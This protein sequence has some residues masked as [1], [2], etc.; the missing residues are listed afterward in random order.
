MIVGNHSAGKSSFI[1]WYIGEGIQKTVSANLTQCML[2]ACQS[3]GAHAACMPIIGRSLHTGHAQG[4]A[5]ETRGF[6]FVT[7]GKKRET[8]TGDATVSQMPRCS[9]TVEISNAVAAGTI[10]SLRRLNLQPNLPT[11]V[12]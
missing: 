1:N 10:C 2:H 12:P 3:L 7:S 5:I 6:T 8:L 11:V 4:V 9:N